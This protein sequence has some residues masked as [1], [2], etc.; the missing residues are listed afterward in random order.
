MNKNPIPTLFL[1]FLLGMGTTSLT[2]IVPSPVVAQNASRN[3]EQLNDLLRRGRDLADTGNYQQAI[4]TYQQAATLDRR[5]P[6]IYSG[7][8]YLYAVQGRFQEAAQ[9]YRNA[10]FLDRNNSSFYY[11]YAHCLA[12]I[13]DNRNATNAYRHAIQLQPNHID[14]YLGLGVVL[15][16]QGY[17]DR[18]LQVYQRVVNL[19]PPNGEVYG[20][21]ATALLEQNQTQSALDLLRQATQRYPNNSKLWMQLGIFLLG[22]EDNDQEALNALQRS[23]NLDPRNPYAQLQIGRILRDRGQNQ[24]A[25]RMFYRVIALDNSVEVQLD[26]G[27][28][29]M[30]LEAYLPAIVA[31]R[32]ATQLAPDNPDSYYKLGFA[33]SARQR[34]REATQMWEKALRLYRQQGDTNRIQELQDLLGFNQPRSPDFDNSQFNPFN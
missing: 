9:A 3:N 12:Q 5:N 32:R 15:M 23:A 30:A 21:M 11:A 24:A 25:D 26:I 34:K 1:A 6:K 17:H 16:R 22:L 10:L 7:I 18:A 27:D 19:N 8:G 31:Y 33:L 4:A 2:G 14:S 28:E 29:L 20:L 13:G